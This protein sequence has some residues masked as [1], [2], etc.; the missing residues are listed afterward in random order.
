LPARNVKRADQAHIQIRQSASRPPRHSRRSRGRK[1]R[2]TRYA[3]A[4]RGKLHCCRQQQ[5]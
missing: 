4:T 5:D 3:N 1:Y 2:A